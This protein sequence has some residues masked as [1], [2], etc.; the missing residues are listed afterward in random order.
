MGH[1]NRTTAKYDKQSKTADGK[2]AGFEG[3]QRLN[4]RL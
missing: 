2:R 4:V 1:V 3:V